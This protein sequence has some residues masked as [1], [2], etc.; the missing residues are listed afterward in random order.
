[1]DAVGKSND[2][3]FT[4]AEELNSSDL[5]NRTFGQHSLYVGTFPFVTIITDGISSRL[6][7]INSRLDNGYSTFIIR[8]ISST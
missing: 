3:L 1:M 6:F 5:L 8:I 7:L 4:S 2:V